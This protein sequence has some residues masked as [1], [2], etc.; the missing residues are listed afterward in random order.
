VGE[1]SGSAL[2]ALEP[3]TTIAIQARGAGRAALEAV[4][5]PLPPCGRMI[6]GDAAILALGPHEWLVATSAERRRDLVIAL[7]GACEGAAA[8]AV[9]V[10]DMYEAWRLSGTGAVGVLAQGCTLDLDRQ[11]VGTCTRTALAGVPIVLAV[12]APE[13]FEIRVER[14][15]AAW[16]ARWI[17]AALS[18]ASRP[19]GTGTPC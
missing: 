2:T 10:S 14:S 16:L 18:P 6:P 3:G 8:Q 9:D 1:T 5:G 4:L 12:R 17:A 15:Y 19:S 7:V 13:T 11:P